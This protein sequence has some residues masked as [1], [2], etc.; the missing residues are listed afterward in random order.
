MRSNDIYPSRRALPANNCKTLTHRDIFPNLRPLRHNVNAM[1]AVALLSFLILSACGGSLTDEQ[2][3]AMRENMELNKIVRITE[4]EMTEAAFAKGRAAVARLEQLQD[5]PGELDSF[6]I[7]NEGRI[8]FIKPGGPFDHSLEEQLMQAYK[9]DTSAWNQE[10]LQKARNGTGGFDSL[11]YTRPVTSQLPKGDKRL[12]GV[13]NIWI[14]KKE[15]V[16]EM[17]KNK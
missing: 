3:K 5:R 7:S 15:L 11:L 9:T 2:R 10:N 14:P 1:K 13:W 16:V 12:E 4:A 6:L 8:R 17:G